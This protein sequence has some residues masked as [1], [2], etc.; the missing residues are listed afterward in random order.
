MISNVFCRLSI[1]ADYSNLSYTNENI[2]K[3]S[4]IFDNKFY[5]NP[6]NQVGNNIQRMQFRNKDNSIIITILNERIDIETTSSK[7]SGFNNE[8]KKQLMIDLSKY[9]KSIYEE[10]SSSIQDGHR[11]AWFTTHILSDINDDEKKEFRNRFIKKIDFFE[12]GYTNEMSVRYSAIKENKVNEIKEI[13][14]TICTINQV[15]ANTTSGIKTGYAID[16]DVNTHQDDLKN[17]FNISS[18]DEFILKAN[19]YE[20]QIMK[21]IYYV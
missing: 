2:L 18:I 3:I 21:E 15:Y 8:E 19:E 16:I 7:D 14:N 5:V 6:I 20:K 10:F 1:F 4:K 12:D 11:L 9:L 17:R 13:I